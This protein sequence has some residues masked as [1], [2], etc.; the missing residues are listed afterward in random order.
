MSSVSVRLRRPRQSSAGACSAC[1]FLGGRR[2]PRRAPPRR[3]GLAPRPGRP[4]RP[5]LRP[6]PTRPCVRDL[7][8][9]DRQPGDQRVQAAHQAGDRRGDH[10]RRAGRAARR[11]AGSRASAAI[12]ST[13]SA[14]PPM[15]PPLNSS[16][17]VSRRNCAS[18]LAASA[19][20]PPSAATNVN[21]V[22][23]SSSSLSDSAPALSARQLGQGVLD[24]A[25]ARAGLVQLHAQLGRLRHGD[26]AVVDGEDRLRLLDLGGDLLD[27]RCFLFFVHVGPFGN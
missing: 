7:L 23:P 16:S 26:P 22:G 10:R 24:D 27:D 8:Q 18:A 17:S 2:P 15:T 11:A 4:R 3:G 5:A 25:E 20:S 9:L 12:C 6:P 13:V 21:A 1:G 14:S 19:T